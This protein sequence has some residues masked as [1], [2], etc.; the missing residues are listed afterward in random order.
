MNTFKQDLSIGRIGEEA[1]IAV[2]SKY[3]KV[4]DA[5]DFD[6]Y[7]DIQLKGIDLFFYVG[8]KKYSVDVKNNINFG[9]TFL[10]IY[11]SNSKPGW[12]KTSEADYIF[13]YD[14]YSK[15]IYY[16]HLN[17]MRQYIRESI[18]N[19]SIDLQKVSNGALGVKINVTYNKLIQEFKSELI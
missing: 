13:L 17:E 10:E 16:Y 3:Y 5:G 6:K 1:V 8:D 2:L 14:R 4:E 15:K 12:F 7:S 18:N 11:Q 19:K 9:S